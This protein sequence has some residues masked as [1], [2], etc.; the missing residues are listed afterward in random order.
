MYFCKGLT[1]NELH[2]LNANHMI[3]RKHTSKRTKQKQE[4]VV[5][6][7][8]FN[9]M[10][11]EILLQVLNF[12]DLHHLIAM[13]QTS[14]YN[15]YFIQQNIFAKNDAIKTEVQIRVSSLERKVLQAAT[16][17]FIKFLSSQHQLANVQLPSF[18]DSLR[19]KVDAKLKKLSDARLQVFERLLGFCADQSTLSSK[20]KLLIVSTILAHFTKYANRMGFVNKDANVLE[21]IHNHLMRALNLDKNMLEDL[22]KRIYKLARVSN[23]ANKELLLIDIRIKEL[24]SL[25]ESIQKSEITSYAQKNP[26]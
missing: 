18:F 8:N 15:H 22:Q 19:F 23:E 25:N 2:N 16:L 5:I 1:L 11:A 9:I 13:S 21:K 6:P 20:T 12:L 14:R 10:P 24:Q 26:R 17:K 7:N 4:T 3:N